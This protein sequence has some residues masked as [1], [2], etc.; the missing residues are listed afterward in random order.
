MKA[1]AF[2]VLMILL[3]AP[4]LPAVQVDMNGDPPQPI[5]RGAVPN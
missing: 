5:T 1:V 4:V 2:A 3:V